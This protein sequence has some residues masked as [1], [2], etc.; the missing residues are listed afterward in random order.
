MGIA[1]RQVQH[2]LI[3]HCHADHDAG[4]MQK[5][6]LEDHI[7]VVT[8]NTIMKS[9]VRKYSAVSDLSQDKI[10]EK[11]TFRAAKVGDWI[12]LLGGLLRVFYSFHTIPTIGFQVQFGGKSL[13]YSGDTFFHPEEITRLATSGVLSPERAQDL[14]AFPWDSDLILHECGVAPIHSPLVCLGQL[15]DPVK[16]R[17]YLVH[18][19]ASS[20][21]KD[22][23]LRGIQLAKDGIE[24]TLVLDV[25]V[26][27]MCAAQSIVAWIKD[28]AAFREL[29]C[30]SSIC[31]L[32]SILTVQDSKYQVGLFNLSTTGFVCTS[33]KQVARALLQW[34]TEVERNEFAQMDLVSCLTRREQVHFTGL[35]TRSGAQTFRRGDKLWE[36]GKNG[37]YVYIV[38][39][40]AVGLTYCVKDDE[41][42]S[43]QHQDSLWQFARL[44]RVLEE[45]YKP[46]LCDLPALYH[47][48][49]LRSTLVCESDEVVCY[50]APA[51]QLMEFLRSAPA[52][53]AKL[54]QDFS[55]EASR[56]QPAPSSSSS[57]NSSSSNSSSSSSE[58]DD[59]SQEEE[60]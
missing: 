31:D 12:P 54:H 17:L 59:D 43:P 24:N 55:F 49:P 10:S 19:T 2:V 25:E 60:L 18:V 45:E 36:A 41:Y 15:P 16:S 4:T 42:N 11:F 34:K 8:T 5:I 46:F 9:F 35:F 38:L 1:P 58:G 6:M 33:S 51:S 22:E 28:S 20:V 13:V 14:L 44:R 27:N 32:V 39:A 3:T 47:G 26:S 50:L 7:T 57:S 56:V 53:L 48:L 23:N 40:G 37:E 30:L 21:A 52:L 29:D